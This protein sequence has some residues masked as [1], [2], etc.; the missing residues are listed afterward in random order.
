MYSTVHPEASPNGLL[1]IV[2]DVYVLLAVCFLLCL[3]LMMCCVLCL[4]WMLIGLGNLAYCLHHLHLLF[5]PSAFDALFG[6]LAWRPIRWM[7]KGRRDMPF[8]V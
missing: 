1:L 4:M 5:K 3:L 6:Q 2:F 7:P 8:G